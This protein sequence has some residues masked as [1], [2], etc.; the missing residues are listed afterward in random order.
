MNTEVRKGDYRRDD[1]KMNGTDNGDDL[2][3]SGWGRY[4]DLSMPLPSERSH[5]EEKLDRC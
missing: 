2:R 5:R 4:G 3:V 1:D